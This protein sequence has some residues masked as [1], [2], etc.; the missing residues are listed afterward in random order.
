MARTISILD[1]NTSNKIAAGEVV[2]KPS[3]V[4]KELLENALDA[5]ATSIEIEVSEGGTQYIRI[6]DN[7]VGMSYEDAKMSVLRHATSKIS[8]ENDLMY[9]KTLGFRGEALPSIAS[10][11][12]FTLITRKRDEDMATKIVIEGGEE[13]SIDETGASIGTSVIVEDLFFNVPARRKFLRTN[14]TEARYISDAITKAALSR[15]DVKFVFI[16]N[17]KQVI[18]T[19]GNNNLADTISALYGAKTKEEL[20]T[21][22]FDRENISISGYLGKPS[23]LK[24]SRQWQT[25]IVNGRVISSRFISKAL[26]HAFSSQ[27]PKNG[28]PFAVIKLNVDTT[29]IDV[30]VHPQKSEIKFSKEQDIYR[31]VYHALTETIN[32]PLQKIEPIVEERTSSAY[33]DSILDAPKSSEQGKIYDFPIKTKPYVLSENISYYNDK[34]I[35]SVSKSESDSFFAVRDAI[36]NQNTLSVDEIVY[37]EDV[38]IN[39]TIWPVGQIDRMYIIA[40]SENTLYLIDQHAAHERII[41]DR[42][43]AS[44]SNIHKQPLLMPIYVELTNS[45][46]EI[47]IEYKELFDEL[48]FEID[49]AGPTLLRLN[50]MPADIDSKEIENFIQQSLK[51]ISDM[52]KPDPMEL[53]S[54]LIAMTS[55]KAAIKGGQTLNI[56]EMKE[57]IEEL[58]KTKHPFTCPHGRPIILTYSSAELGRMF[59]RT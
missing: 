47:A 53:R 42:L 54:E 31:Y 41:F 37:E 44:K 4:V 22:N 36:A 57:L 9:I 52:K 25:I 46:M 32:T 33:L 8:T 16:N 19:P 2:E 5:G 18:N 21:V 1:T 26:D 59:K 11:S 28:Y 45:D 49:E 34:P 48:C 10:V 43:S 50:T 29:E 35:T 14:N 38:S 39:D 56:R 40:Q 27:L 20:L 15:A 58:M 7:G 24:S 17:S 30:N 13:Q 3:S 51:Y 12:K 55:C 23:I 6:T